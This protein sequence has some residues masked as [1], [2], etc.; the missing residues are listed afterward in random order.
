MEYLHRASSRWSFRQKAWSALAVALVAALS[1]AYSAGRLKSDFNRRDLAGDGPGY[2]IEVFNENFE[3]LSSG[4]GAVD[5]QAT[6][7]QRFYVRFK[8]CPQNGGGCS[9]L[10]GF[11]DDISRGLHFLPAEKD[12]LLLSAIGASAII[13]LKKHEERHDETVSFVRKILVANPRQSPTYRSEDIGEVR[14]HVTYTSRY[15]DHVKA[16]ETLRSFHLAD[17]AEQGGFMSIPGVTTEV[18]LDT[19]GKKQVEERLGMVVDRTEK[20]LE[21]L[22]VHDLPWSSRNRSKVATFSCALCHFGKAAGVMVPGLGN[23]NVSPSAM[24]EAALEAHA[25]LKYKIVR[26][27]QKVFKSNENL[28][29]EK[30]GEASALRIVT[31]LANPQYSNLTQGLTAVNQT[32]LRFYRDTGVPVPPDFPRAPSKGQAMWGLGVKRSAGGQFSDAGSDGGSAAWAAGY[33]MGSEMPLEVIRENLPKLEIAQDAFGKLLSPRY[34]FQID[35]EK[36]RAGSN[37]FEINC[38][39]CHAANG[40]Y[41]RDPQG[42]PLFRPP[43][44]VALDEV[45]TEPERAAL[46]RGLDKVLEKHPFKDITRLTPPEKRPFEGYYSPR[47]NGIWSRF[48]YLHNGSVPSLMALLTAPKDRPKVFSLKRAGEFDRFDPVRV[49]LTAPATAMEQQELE[50]K[51]K[52]GAQDV[53]DISRDEHSNQ[54]HRKGLGLTYEEKIELIEYLK[55]L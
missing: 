15:L 55:T 23:K 54:G 12:D 8:F 13:T 34:P 24:A 46:F 36:A 17:Y 6:D 25:S 14:F 45:G 30:E 26:S 16:S 37:H 22:G 11:A 3:L 39:K 19:L 27:V 49:G 41:E 21:I 2:L 1:V 33:D 35:R 32:P 53:Y 44:L 9:W 7:S 38:A 47:L 4:R 48:P 10:R 52:T 5:L 18:I 43:L 51:A 42:H 40:A 29:L 50:R 31:M 28:K 20:G